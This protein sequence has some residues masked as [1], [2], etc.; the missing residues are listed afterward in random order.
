MALLPCFATA[1]PAAAAT[2][3]V[4]VEMLKV[5]YP[6]PPVPQVSKRVVLTLGLI[7]VANF[8]I[9]FAN[10][11]ISSIHSPFKWRA[12]KRAPICPGVAF[13]DIMSFITFS[14]STRLR[15]SREVTFTIA[16]R[17]LLDCSIWVDIIA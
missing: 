11:D 14:D 13:P 4:K 16:A 10:A 6:S 1:H 12:V 15:S 2:R 9:I 7:C 8:R 5:L 3:A 17:M